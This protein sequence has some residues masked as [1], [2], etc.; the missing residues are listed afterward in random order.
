[1]PSALAMALPL[2][3]LALKLM[4]YNTLSKVS[5]QLDA[6]IALQSIEHIRKLMIQT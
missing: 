1:M 4:A 6:A 2:Q 3:L 5:Q